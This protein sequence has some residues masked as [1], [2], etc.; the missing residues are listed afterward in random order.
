MRRA[1]TLIELL[2]VISI[3]AL[4]IAI[5]LPVLSSVKYE[6]NNFLCLNRQRQ[7]VIAATAYATDNK[8][9][10]PDRGIDNT[11]AGEPL[12][13]RWAARMWITQ[14]VDDNLDEVLGE[15]ISE[16]T[17]VWVCPLYDGAHATG[18]FAGCLEHGKGHYNGGGNEF[19]WTTYSFHGGLKERTHR[20]H[21]YNPGDRRKIDEP[22]IIELSDG[23]TYESG[24]LMSDVPVDDNA[25]VPCYYP[26]QTGRFPSRGPQA[27][28]PGVTT[29]HQPKPGVRTQFVNEYGYRIN[30]VGGPA[31]TNWA[32][33]DG[34]AEVRILTPGNGLLTS[35]EWV[36]VSDDAGRYMMFPD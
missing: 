6:S 29:C 22:Y 34:S 3:I 15:Y 17:A 2:V 20:S 26:N 5:L 9:L 14:T 24:L 30:G 28:W 1:F 12:W 4:L 35:D 7:W 31:H 27:P 13:A 19:R 36:A 10:Y 25:W 8:E 33:N 16:E 23:R 11:N 18:A 32:Y 21:V